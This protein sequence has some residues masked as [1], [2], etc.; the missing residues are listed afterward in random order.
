MGV[1]RGFNLR[2]KA[3]FMLFLML[4]LMFAQFSVVVAQDEATVDESLNSGV[5]PENYEGCYEKEYL[6]G[7][8]SS[9]ETGSVSNINNFEI[10][11]GIEGTDSDQT[12]SVFSDDV[13]E[14]DSEKIGLFSPGCGPVECGAEGPIYGQFCKCESGNGKSICK[15]ENKCSDGHIINCGKSQKVTKDI[16]VIFAEKDNGLVMFFIPDSL[17]K[18]Q[19]E[20]KEFSIENNIN[21]SMNNSYFYRIIQ[22]EDGNASVNIYYVSNIY[23]VSE[24]G[25]VSGGV[26]SVYTINVYWSEDSSK[27]E[28]STSLNATNFLP[29]KYD[30]YKLVKI[31]NK[32]ENNKQINLSVIEKNNGVVN[33]ETIDRN[34]EGYL[35]L[36]SKQYVTEE[37]VPDVI[38]GEL[39]GECTQT[40]TGHVEYVLVG[41]EF[42]S[43]G[44]LPSAPTYESETFND[45]SDLYPA[46]FMEDGKYYPVKNSDI[47]SDINLPAVKTSEGVVGQISIGKSTYGISE[48]EIALVGLSSGFS[49]V[50]LVPPEGVRIQ[51]EVSFGSPL[52][53]DKVNVD[54]D[55]VSRLPSY[56]NIFQ[57]KGWIAESKTD[58]A[59]QTIRNFCDADNFLPGA[60]LEYVIAA[61]FK[62]EGVT[63]NPDNIKNMYPVRLITSDNYCTMKIDLSSVNTKDYNSLY[64]IDF[65]AVYSVET[66]EGKLYY[67]MEAADSFKFWSGSQT[68]PSADPADYENRDSIRMTMYTA[69]GSELSEI[70]NSKLFGAS[71][72]I[73]NMLKGSP[74]ICVPN[75]ITCES[76]CIKEGGKYYAKSLVGNDCSAVGLKQMGEIDPKYLTEKD[77]VCC[78]ENPDAKCGGL[79]QPLCDYGCKD[80]LSACKKEGDS[81][82]VCKE[83]CVGGKNVNPA[84]INENG[85]ITQCSE[86]DKKSSPEKC[87]GTLVD[88]NQ[89]VTSGVSGNTTI[90]SD[91]P[92]IVI[93]SIVV[94][95]DASVQTISLDNSTPEYIQKLLK[96]RFE[97]LEGWSFEDIM[98]SADLVSVTDSNDVHRVL[99]A[100]VPYGTEENPGFGYFDTLVFDMEIPTFNL[101]N[102][103][104]KVKIEQAGSPGRE[105]ERFWY[106][107]SPTKGII[108]ILD[109]VEAVEGMSSD[110]TSGSNTGNKIESDENQI[111]YEIPSIENKQFSLDET[112][113]I[114]KA[115]NKYFRE[116]SRYDSKKDNL[117]SYYKSIIELFSLSYT[118]S[119]KPELG[120]KFAEETMKYTTEQKEEL[121]NQFDE[122]IRDSIKAYNAQIITDNIAAA[123]AAA[124]VVLSSQKNPKTEPDNSF[125]E[126]V[127]MVW[128]NPTRSL[129][130]NPNSGVAF[131]NSAVGMQGMAIDETTKLLIN[132]ESFNI[133]NIYTPLAIR[134]IKELNDKDNSGFAED[135][136]KD[137]MYYRTAVSEKKDKPIDEA[138]LYLNHLYYTPAVLR[139]VDNYVNVMY[140]NFWCIDRGFIQDW[141]YYDACQI[142]F[143]QRVNNYMTYT[144]NFFGST[145][146]LDDFFI[147]EESYLNKDRKEMDAAA[148]IMHWTAVGNIVFTLAIGMATGSVIAG[149]VSK[150]ANI[151][152]TLYYSVIAVLGVGTIASVGI[153]SYQHYMC[154]DKAKMDEASFKSK[155]YTQDSDLEATNTILARCIEDTAM[156][157]AFFAGGFLTG[158]KPIAKSMSEQKVSVNFFKRIFSKEL[159]EKPR[160]KYAIKGTKVKTVGGKKV[161]NFKFREKSPAVQKMSQAFTEMFKTGE[162]QYVASYYMNFMDDLYATAKAKLVA[163]KDFLPT[164]KTRRLVSEK[165]INRIKTNVKKAG[166]TEQQEAM[167]LQRID[168]EVARMQSEFETAVTKYQAAK[169]VSLAEANN[170][171]AAETAKISEK[172]KTTTVKSKEKPLNKEKSVMKPVE[173]RP[174][175]KSG[176][177]A[178]QMVVMDGHGG[179]VQDA[180]FVK[181]SSNVKFIGGV[182]DG[183][184]G[185]GSKAALSAKIALEGVDD[186]GKHIAGL[187]DK[188]DDL[189]GMYEDDIPKLFNE[190]DNYAKEVLE[191]II[192]KQ[193]DG[194]TT[195][196]VVAAVTKNNELITYRIG[197]TEVRVVRK[198]GLFSQNKIIYHTDQL[199]TAEGKPL[200][201]GEIMSFECGR[202]WEEGS[203]FQAVRSN[204]PNQIG[205]KCMIDRGYMSV[206]VINPGDRIILSS[207]GFTPRKGSLNNNQIKKIVAAAKSPEE[208]EQSLIRESLNSIKKNLGSENK[209]DDLGNIVAFID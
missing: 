186:G 137:M 183:V 46:L 142:L 122:Y 77:Y 20:I 208:A 83:S 19:T 13:P 57:L 184:S 111:A 169:K 115:M 91:M 64:T 187:V 73:S 38:E 194:A 120:T 6:K 131:G 145:D 168:D 126:Y 175:V 205:G 147:S 98:I 127:K 104:L 89:G 134:R 113:R 162:N 40:N 49:P 132:K 121:V 14:Q 29:D 151:G 9:L 158:A 44:K 160:I 34:N 197:D 164:P 50:S 81:G 21:K 116:K 82:G 48:K 88:P 52:A 84:E 148:S 112:N 22:K 154:F 133:E 176:K 75:E 15:L 177:G 90:N 3:I 159:F 100:S 25:Y 74:D 155:Y 191:P 138:H 35:I 110:G 31:L 32:D 143:V 71:F 124:D 24:G 146:S 45:S 17:N 53:K 103:K 8:S 59:G 173:A 87:E 209:G 11:E 80:G 170:I 102:Y 30:D 196:V 192:Y 108:K 165:E 139:D 5:P 41:A 85:V 61:V 201:D 179:V 117:D 39:T 119:K 203:A 156:T 101:G 94:D 114:A 18:E 204:G 10:L 206:H 70:L 92:E 12:C 128:K 200:F 190:I 144:E 199:F 26:L 36:L 69:K 129:I 207:D 58:G 16:D 54:K 96:L 28:F 65:L 163:Y 76:D 95:N 47:S 178:V 4:S 2:I 166:L 130:Y 56:E 161:T 78:F 140:M 43:D 23:D 68:T 97:N 188:F 67:N 195:T 174:G 106:G 109:G 150:V 185:A 157:V 66:P 72:K 55:Y 60:K 149:V 37:C 63:D 135:T 198:Y 202:V 189:I 62:G 107:D 180:V 141:T 152:K 125:W 33:N 172:Q 27:P 136:T 171:I 153:V 1:G 118:L 79:D 123:V 86:K 51:V 105:T 42:G 93:K 99:F 193:T 181:A 167:V 7:E 182:A